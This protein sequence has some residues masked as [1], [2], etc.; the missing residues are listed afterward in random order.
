MSIALDSKALR[1]ME[2]RLSPVKQ[3][4]AVVPLLFVALQPLARN[5]S[6]RLCFDSHKSFATI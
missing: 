1:T 4:K 6:S 3:T 2:K 5:V